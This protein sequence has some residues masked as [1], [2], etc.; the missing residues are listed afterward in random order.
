M[1]RPIASSSKPPAVV[2]PPVDSGSLVPVLA[3]R[4]Q[5]VLLYGYVVPAI[6]RFLASASWQSMICFMSSNIRPPKAR[7]G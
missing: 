4:R 5:M 1:T 2:W 6:R 7:S 3:A